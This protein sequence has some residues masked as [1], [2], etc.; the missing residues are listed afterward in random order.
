MDHKNLHL[1]TIQNGTVKD[2]TTPSKI[3]SVLKNRSIVKIRTISS[4]NKQ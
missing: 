4:K 2:S 3:F 1:E